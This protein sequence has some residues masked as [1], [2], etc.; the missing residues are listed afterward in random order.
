MLLQDIKTMGTAQTK[1]EPKIIA[2]EPIEEQGIILTYLIDCKSSIFKPM[3]YSKHNCEVFDRRIEK[4]VLEEQKKALENYEEVKS[5]GRTCII[6]L[7]FLNLCSIGELNLA[8]C[9]MGAGIFFFYFQLLGRVKR[10]YMLASYRVRMF[11]LLEQDRIK[12]TEEEMDLLDEEERS[13]YEQNKE[14][15]I[16]NAMLVCNPKVLKKHFGEK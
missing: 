1:E 8:T 6:T 14:L 13:L 2:Y 11:K 10:R 15:C 12:L 3:I 16:G 4:N 9:L 5:L 7:V